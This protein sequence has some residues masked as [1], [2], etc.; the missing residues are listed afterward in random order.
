MEKAGRKT[1]ETGSRRK[2]GSRIVSGK[3]IHQVV[4]TVSSRNS[5]HNSRCITVPGHFRKEVRVGPPG[6]T[7]VLRLA[8]YM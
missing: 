7:S 2:T 5:G 8:F 6:H 4:Y 3:L 1:V